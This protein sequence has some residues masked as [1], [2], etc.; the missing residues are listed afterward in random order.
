M[1]AAAGLHMDYGMDRSMDRPINK[2]S[3]GILL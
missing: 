1:G 3:V 2:A